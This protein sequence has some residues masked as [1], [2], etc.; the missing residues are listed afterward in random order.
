MADIDHAPDDEPIPL[1]NIFEVRTALQKHGPG[2]ISDLLSD[3]GREELIELIFGAAR[4][5]MIK[6]HRHDWDRYFSGWICLTCR[7][8]SGHD[9]SHDPISGRP[10]P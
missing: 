8:K 9:Y 6:G 10:R 4:L 2:A 3:W 1:D 7:L 5:P